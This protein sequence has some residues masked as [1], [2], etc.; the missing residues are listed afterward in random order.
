MK[1][2]YN[3]LTALKQHPGYD[4]LMALWAFQFQKI[5]SAVR[6]AAK[7]N[8]ELNWRY[9]AGQQ[10]GFELAITQIERSLKEMEEKSDEAPANVEAQ[11]QVD[12]LLRKIKG[13]VS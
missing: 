2:E 11:A 9:F 6:K 5:V 12:D 7:Q 1:A 10:E 8:K 4:I 13:D 3:H